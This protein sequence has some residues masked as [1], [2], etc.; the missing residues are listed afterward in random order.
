MSLARQI[1]ILISLLLLVV[2]GGSFTVNVFHARHYLNQQL[3]AHAQ[4]T[5]TALGLALGSVWAQGDQTGMQSMLTAI[6][7]SGYYRYIA[8]KNMQGEILLERQ[9]QIAIDSVPAW[10]VRWLPLQTPTR[11][12][13]V[14]QGWRQAGQVLVSS[15][16]GYA[17][18]QLWNAAQ[19][20]LQWFIGAWIMALILVIILVR[21]ALAPLAAMER[22][23]QAISAGQFKLL[24][25]IPWTREL[26]QVALALNRMSGKVE[27]LLSEK[28]QAITQLEEK[29]NL[30]P[31]TGLYNRAFFEDGL[32]FLMQTD[33]EFSSG[34][35]LLVRLSSL[36][37]TN[38]RW[39]FSAGDEMLQQ[40]AR[41]LRDLAAEM[42]PATAARMGGA[43]LALLV[44]ELSQDEAL[45][46]ADRLLTALAE[47]MSESG[48]KMHAAH[49]GI[50]MRSQ[51]INTPGKLLAQADMALRAAQNQGAYVRFAFRQEEVG[52]PTVRGAA[53]WRVLFEQALVEH[54]LLLYQQPVLDAASMA[55]IYHELLARVR[56]TDGHLIAAGVFMPMA[57]RL[58]LA[59]DFDRAIIKI[60]LNSLPP[61]N[62]LYTLNLSPDTI[63]DSAFAAWLSQI[64]I[65]HPGTASRILFEFSERSAVEYPA[66]LVAFIDRLTPTGCR[67]GFNHVGM[68]PDA[69]VRIR[70]FHPWMI[71][72]DGSLLQG[73]K[74]NPAKRA[75]LQMINALAQDLDCL[76]VVSGVETQAQLEQLCAMGVPALQGRA[77]A[78]PGPL[79]G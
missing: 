60:A 10:F 77:L 3:G 54:R 53:E 35:L 26:R 63:L 19:T 68:A 37:E 72:T 27:H 48:A 11:T 41:L 71:K 55:P 30:D 25:R 8:V 75:L 12:A 73:L 79:S 44:Q 65:K 57:H 52:A 58:G 24:A 34:A 66:Q 51:V 16:P 78:A 14:M 6:A 15:H 42:Q 64:F 23:A 62:I 46:L 1:L 5:A 18:Q 29:A 74:G 69:L 67:F 40:A 45:A 61:G 49:I 43:E 36:P 47:C 21:C 4:D 7:D 13:L 9:P 33:E 38:D 56:D 28:L 2:L 32:Q 50:G 70:H 76:F 59:Q 20:L 31:L 17:Y 39:G 22:Q